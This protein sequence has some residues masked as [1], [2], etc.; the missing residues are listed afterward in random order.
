MGASADEI[1]CITG[2]TK[3]DPELACFITAADLKVARVAECDPSLT[4]AELDV[5]ANWY[6]AYLLASGRSDINAS[7]SEEQFEQYKVK[8]GTSSTSQAQMYWDTANSLS[9][10]CLSQTDKPKPSMYF[11]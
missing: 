6:A 3:T 4:T 8:F 7:K 9:G 5:I 1:R 11:T 2:S 10:G